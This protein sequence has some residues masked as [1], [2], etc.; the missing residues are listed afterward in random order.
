MNTQKTDINQEI[1]IRDQSGDPFTAVWNWLLD[2]TDMGGTEKLVWIALKSF[3]GFREIRPSVKTVARRASVSVRTVQRSFDVLSKKGFLRVE[4]RSRPDGG[5]AANRYILLPFPPRTRKDGAG[6]TVTPAP[7]CHGDTPPD[8]T[9]SPP[10]VTQCHPKEKIELIKDKTTT[11]L[12]P[13]L[14]EQRHV[15]KVLSG[16]KS[17]T[18]LPDNSPKAP[19]P[20]VVVDDIKK[21]VIGT[22]FQKLTDQVLLHVIKRFGCKHVFDT[23]DVLTS[24]YKKS[25]KLVKDPVAVLITSLSKGVTPPYDYVP[26]HE[27]IEKERKAR[28]E[29]EIKRIA[30]QEKAKAEEDAYRK[31]SE[32]FDALPEEERNQWLEKARA[33]M[34]SNLGNAKIA[35][36][37]IAISLFRGG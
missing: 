20:V 32:E 5:D 33:T 2:R 25:G 23:L 16:Q 12:T 30:A 18:E 11:S 9:L 1:E 15:E 37:S 6:D 35:T 22:Q 3:A 10:L 34:H 36:R 27:R 13:L 24:I 14:P 21:L 19:E 8:A 4:R 28:E 26:Y 29:A 17:L 7:R 31:K